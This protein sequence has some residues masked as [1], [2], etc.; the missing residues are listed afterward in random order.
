MNYKRDSR[1]MDQSAKRLCLDV[2]NL[3]IDEN[4]YARVNAELKHLHQGTVNPA[5]GS[6][7]TIHSMSP[8][9]P[10]P[11]AMRTQQSQPPSD[12]AQQQQ[13][14]QQQQHHTHRYHQNGSAPQQLG[15]MLHSFITGGGGSSSSTMPPPIVDIMR[16]G[17][18]HVNIIN[19]T[20]TN[21]PMYEI[22][23]CGHNERTRCMECVG[24][25]VH[26]VPVDIYH[27]FESIFF[28][29]PASMQSNMAEAQSYGVSL[30]SLVNGEIHFP[31]FASL[32]GDLNLPPQFCFLDCGSGRGKAVVAAAL[33]FPKAQL[34]GL[35]IRP[36]LVNISQNLDL[37]HDVKSRVRFVETCFFDVN[38]SE[39]DVIFINATGFEAELIKRVEKK[40]AEEARKT[41]RLIV[42]SVQLRATGFTELLPARRYRMSWG[43]ATVYTYRGSSLAA[44]GKKADNMSL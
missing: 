32:L 17:Q 13:Q 30:R 15:G 9:Q 24:R 37:R 12:S 44:A 35:E 22:V 10:N 2:A 4:P 33:L 20:M 42:L 23:T 8:P 29:A 18:A 28:S 19:E 40:I 5:S 36:H 14:Q 6:M 3:C 16:Q 11:R 21:F 25:K 27:G 34:C 26:Q 43:N 31:A 38:W 1:W 39:A 7:Q 41:A